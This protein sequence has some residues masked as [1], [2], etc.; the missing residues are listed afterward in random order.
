[1]SMYQYCILRH[2][3]HAISTQYY[4]TLEIK[5]IL[6]SCDTQDS[7]ALILIAFLLLRSMV[8]CVSCFEVK[9][10]QLTEHQFN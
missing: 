10:V 9:V 7:P 6:L 5:K 2:A 1:M 8:K 4:Y 3:H